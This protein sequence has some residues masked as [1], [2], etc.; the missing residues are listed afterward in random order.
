MTTVLEYSLALLPVLLFLVA[1]VVLDSFKL[2]RLRAILFTILIG[3]LAAVVLI[4]VNS[5]LSDSLRLNRME[6]TR[7]L[8]P[9][10]EEIIKSLYLV[11]IIATNRTGFLV[12]SAIRGFALG[13]GFALA[14]NVFYHVTLGEHSIGLWI[15]RGFGTAF[16]HG[17]T[18]TVFAIVSRTIRDRQIWPGLQGFLPGL[19]LAIVV[20]SLFNQFLL[21]PVVLT[22]VTLLTLSVVT[23]IVFTY[24]EK[25]TRDWLG[26]GLDLHM[27]LI[28]SISTGDISDS[29]VGKYLN[30]L[31][32]KFKP[33]VVADML[34][35]LRINA[36]LAAAA[37]GVM[38]A[39]EVGL[40]LPPDTSLRGKF[41]ELKYLERTVGRTGRLALHPLLKYHSVQQWE[42]NLLVSSVR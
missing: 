15:V 38:L 31:I 21:P 36:E 7:Y 29:H 23:I 10:T 14:E 8:A 27:D 11:Y 33:M 9:A 22:A 19:A 26:S 2:V 30:A 28:E 20:H 13:A 16:L 24:S 37:K 18:M 39:R 41:K 17:G 34:C 40:K 32:T 42:K 12:D 4:Y 3:G 5:W 6:F 25:K 35:L 1:L